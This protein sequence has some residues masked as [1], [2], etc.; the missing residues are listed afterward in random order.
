MNKVL[1][2]TLLTS[3]LLTGCVSGFGSEP[4]NMRENA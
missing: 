4:N 1:L 3:S 2:T